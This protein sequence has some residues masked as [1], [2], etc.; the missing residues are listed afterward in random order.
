[1]YMCVALVAACKDQMQGCDWAHRYLHST[2]SARAVVTDTGPGP[3]VEMATIDQRG[4]TGPS[5]TLFAHTGMLL[6]E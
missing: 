1:M 5:I 6:H 2:Y 3:K 4:N